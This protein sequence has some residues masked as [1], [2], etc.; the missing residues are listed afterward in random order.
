VNSGQLPPAQFS[1]FGA[2]QSSLSGSPS[3]EHALG[4]I[5][6]AANGISP[7]QVPTW[8]SRIGAPALRGSE[9]SVK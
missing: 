6:G 4:A 5:Y 7:D 1:V 3:E 2:Q 9:V 8:V